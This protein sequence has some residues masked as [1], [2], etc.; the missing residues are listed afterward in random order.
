[1]EVA[2]I[3]LYVV[4]NVVHKSPQQGIDCDIKKANKKDSWGKKCPLM[5][6]KLNLYSIFVHRKSIFPYSLK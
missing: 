2:D 1:M 5:N 4:S 3:Y 6:N